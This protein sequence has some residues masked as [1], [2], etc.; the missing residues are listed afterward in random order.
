MPASC[1]GCISKYLFYFVGILVTLG[2]NLGIRE[3]RIL[4]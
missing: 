2:F 3:G 1:F 4:L